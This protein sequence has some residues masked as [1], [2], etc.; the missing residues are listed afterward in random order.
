ME[1]KLSKVPVIA[2]V[3]DDDSFR[4]ATMSFIRSLGYAVVQFASAE[5]FLKSDRLHD[6]D[7]LISDVQM[8]GMNGVELQGELIAQGHHLPIIFVTAFSEMRAR[9]QALAAGAIGFLAK[10]FNDEMLIT[11]LSEALGT[12]R[13][14]RIFSDRHRLTSSVTGMPRPALQ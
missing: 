11:C 13:P 12:R 4:R 14:S 8:P 3:D 7:C 9:Q 2:I 6:T 5:A 10:P 1:A